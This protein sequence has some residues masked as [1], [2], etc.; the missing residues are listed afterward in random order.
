LL[1]R[2]P[3]EVAAHADG[4]ARPAEP[5]LIAEVLDIADQR[6]V[7]DERHRA[8]QPDWSYDHPASGQWPAERLG[9]HRIPQ[10][11]EA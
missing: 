11:L 2:F 6:A 8:K 3:D 10:P 7:V 1:E 4:R 5:E 9:E